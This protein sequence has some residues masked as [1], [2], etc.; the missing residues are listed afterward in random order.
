MNDEQKV[1]HEYTFD[2]DK[3]PLTKNI[4]ALHQEGNYLVGV[5]EHGVRFRQR[6]PAGK[7]LNQKEGKYV[8]DDMVVD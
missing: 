4:Q 1:E 5:T 3:M 7:I 6:I 8:F 2:I